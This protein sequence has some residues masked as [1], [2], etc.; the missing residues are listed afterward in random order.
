MEAAAP[1]NPPPTTPTVSGAF[2]ISPLQVSLALG[3]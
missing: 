3:S 1:V 2:R